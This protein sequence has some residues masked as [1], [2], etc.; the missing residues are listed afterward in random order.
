MSILPPK[1]QYQGNEPQFIKLTGSSYYNKYC[2]ST[3]TRGANS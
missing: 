2:Y 1:Q 3:G